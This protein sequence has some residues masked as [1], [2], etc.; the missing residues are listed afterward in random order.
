MADTVINVQNL[1]KDYGKKR[2]VLQINLDIK[3][4]ETVGFIGTNGSGKTTTIR[5]M[6]GFVRPD[7]G[8]VRIM[9]K[10]TWKDATRIKEYVSY[11]PGEIAFPALPTGTAFLK[12][13][14]EMLGIKDYT[15]M[16]YLLK[17]LQ[18]D[19]TANLK[20]MS[21]GMKQKTAI[22]AAL[23]GDK[24][25]LILDEPTTGLDPLM[26]DVFLNLMRQEKAKGRTIFMSSQIMEEM[27][28][29]CD[30]VAVIDQ[31]HLLGILDVHQ[32]RHEAIK[33]FTV[34][35]AKAEDCRRFQEEWQIDTVAGENEKTCNV[36]VPKN[37]VGSFLAMMRQY[38]IAALRESRRT[39]EDAFKDLYRA[40][41]EERK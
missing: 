1:T 14:A 25:I 28:E 3:Q 13:Q 33:H 39:L 36:T 11:V 24:E 8:T 30:R 41:K 27:E 17:L 38:P 12:T 35:F 2:G 22:V 9:G 29:I 21:K 7:E 37:E 40:G 18:L 6:M 15:Y 23:M 31:G 34:K 20:R 4:G 32:F 26:R 10:D 19:P 16:N 5:N